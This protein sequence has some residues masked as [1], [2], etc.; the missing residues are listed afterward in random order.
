M[1]FDG[2]ALSRAPQEQ[3]PLEESVGISGCHVECIDRTRNHDISFASHHVWVYQ[4]IYQL[5]QISGGSWLGRNTNTGKKRRLEEL[6]SLR[7]RRN[8]GNYALWNPSLED[9]VPC[10]LRVWV[11]TSYWSRTTCHLSQSSNGEFPLCSSIFHAAREVGPEAYKSS[12]LPR[13]KSL[14]YKVNCYWTRTLLSQVEFFKI[15]VYNVYP[16]YSSTK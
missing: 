12:E 5:V 2:S 1:S 11:L 6:R 15:V 9:F 16:F 8:V 4:R 7:R 3:R 14:W 10:G 13:C